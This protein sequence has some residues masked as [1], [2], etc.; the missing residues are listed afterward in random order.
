MLKNKKQQKSMANKVKEAYE[1]EEVSNEQEAETVT[2]ELNEAGAEEETV[3]N[4]SPVEKEFSDMNALIA[5]LDRI[6]QALDEQQQKTNEM[7]TR[8]LRAV[9]D[10][11]NY[12][13]RMIREKEELSKLAVSGFAEDLLPIVDNFKLGM[14]A[15]NA[16][17]EAKVVSDGLGMVLG[18][19]LEVLKSKGIEEISPKGEEFDPQFHECVSHLPHE[20]IPEDH[21]IETIRSGYKIKDR[22]IRAATVLVSS[23][24]NS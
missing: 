3:G 8:Y 18:Q 12:R 7:Q 6:S 9:A 14:T 19:F 24:N 13:K 10:L 4:V 2:V 15:A 20:E 16:H 22:L 21:V 23:G 1:K 17:P 5:E 11:E